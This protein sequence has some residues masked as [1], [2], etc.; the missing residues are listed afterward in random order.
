ML[1]PK[2]LRQWK[3]ALVCVCVDHLYRCKTSLRYLSVFV[4][5]HDFLFHAGGQCTTDRHCPTKTLSVRGDT[6]PDQLC[7]PASIFHFSEWQ[8]PACR[9]VS[10]SSLWTKLHQNLPQ[11]KDAENIPGTLCPTVFKPLYGFRNL[12]YCRLH[13]MEQL[14]LAR[15]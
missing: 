15:T 13:Q 4:M 3:F 11:S 7:V 8:V 9:F 14:H 2:V 10:F 5:V 6:E 12:I 1:T